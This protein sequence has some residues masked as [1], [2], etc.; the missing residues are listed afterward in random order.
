LKRFDLNTQAI[1]TV[2]TYPG[3]V[4]GVPDFLEIGESLKPVSQNIIPF[5]AVGATDSGVVTIY[6]K[7]SN[8]LS[9]TAFSKEEAP[10]GTRTA[11]ADVNGDGIPDLIVSAGT[12]GIARVRVYDGDTQKLLTTIDAFEPGFTGGVNVAA[13]D[14]NSDGLAEIIVSADNGGGPRVRI[15]NGA[16][17]K[18]IADFFGIEDPTFRG[19]ARISMGD[20][21]GDGFA[22]LIVAAGFGGGPRI[23]IFDG[24]SL[25]MNV[26]FV[27]LVPDFF[28][29]EPTL[30]NGTFVASGDL[31]GD[32]FDDLVAGGGPG[33]G[34]RVFAIDGKSL[35]PNG[36]KVELANFFS[37]DINSTGGVRVVVKDL[38]GDIFADIVAASG[39]M[40]APQIIQYAGKGLVPNS[41]PTELG[42]LPGL[43]VGSRGGFYVG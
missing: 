34:P 22:D 27:K 24:K 35:L 1:S 32:G 30:R 26:T 29:F 5:T 16:D 9:I 6:D 18:Q 37:G 11:L 12:G 2:K 17:F 20:I 7:Q 42:Q 8:L 38:D 28:L 13:A 14:L 25:A 39:D 15:F 10:N 21:N 23:A 41:I 19:G 43:S 40:A 4:L 3:I 36:N 33:G 31:N